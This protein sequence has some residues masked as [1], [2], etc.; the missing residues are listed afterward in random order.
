MDDNMRFFAKNHVRGVVE[1]GNWQSPHGAM[2]GLTGYL[3]A[4]YLWNPDA[5]QE[6]T[7]REYLEGVYGP[8]AIPIKAYLD[9]LADKV[10]KEK[11][12]LP[13]YGSRV[14]PYL[15][16][17]LMEKAD[18]LWDEAE[19]LAA[20]NPGFLKQVRLARLS[21]DYAIIEHYHLQPGGMIHYEGNPRKGK[22]GRIDPA[23]EARVRRFLNVFESSGATHIREGKP[24][25][26]DYITWLKSLLPP[27]SRQT[28]P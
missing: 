2:S 22:V 4:K 7:T 26:A 19:L 14:P 11:I 8:A 13:I 20:P 15:T 28:P 12:P 23:F 9:L 17:E 24:D 27:D 5:D 10:E 21:P 16:V 6:S 25:S 3:A 18:A 1:Q